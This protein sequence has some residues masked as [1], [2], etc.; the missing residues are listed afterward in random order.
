MGLK[1]TH[2]EKHLLKGYKILLHSIVLLINRLVISR[3]LKVKMHYLH[4]VC[5]CYSSKENKI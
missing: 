2:S 1:L 5:S 4:L 3:D